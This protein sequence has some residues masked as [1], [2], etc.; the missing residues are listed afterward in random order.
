MRTQ[1]LTISLDQATIRKAKVIAAQR[2]TSVS[3]LVT[4]VI[5]R[6]AGDED[7]YQAAMREALETL[8]HGFDLGGTIH[9]TRD[10]LHDR[11]SLR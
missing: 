6:L 5:E 8:D 4:E 9:A 10:E 3:R 2:G 7:A 11:P 1:N